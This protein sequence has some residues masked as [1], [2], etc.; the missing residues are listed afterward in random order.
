MSGER[1]AG[2]PQF[3]K[4]IQEQAAYLSTKGWFHSIELP[5]GDVIRGLHTIQQLRERLDAF[6]IPRDLSGKRA[7]DIG[8]WTGWFSFELERRGAEVVAMDCL[9]LEE[10]LAARELLG[11]RVELRVLDMDELSPESAGQFDYVLFLGVLYHLRHPLLGLE[12]LC[13]VTREAA[14]VESYVTD[15]GLPAAQWAEAPNLLEFYETDELGGQFD[16]WYGPNINCLLAMCRAAG[17]ARVKLESVESVRARVSCYRN[18][19]PPPAHTMESAPVIHAAVNNRTSDIFFHQGKDEYVCVYFQSR[20][21]GLTMNCMHAEIDGFGVP[22][23]A[24]ADLGRNGWQLNFRCPPWLPAG[25]HEVRLRTT[26][27]QY[28]EPFI[29]EKRLAPSASG[30]KLSNSAPGRAL[31]DKPTS[32][33]P[34]FTALESNLTESVVFQ[35]CRNEQM[36]CWFASEEAGLRRESVMVEIDGTMAPVL[37][38]T[39]LRGGKWQANAKPPGNLE[40]GTHAVRLR[41]AQS[42]WSRPLEMLIKDKDST[43]QP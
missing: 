25:P 21:R 9:E 36:I 34:V 20:E 17:F 30:G 39:D 27:S 31:P 7:L 1:L 6:P 11:S 26:Q 12:R 37:F 15:G 4:G 13:S 8:A 3:L 10:F 42:D 29:I 24:L 22:A 38:L 18:W 23:M 41:T 33:A 35:G 32:P 28:S 5:G 19:E 43:P 40:S 16:N 14:F 2:N